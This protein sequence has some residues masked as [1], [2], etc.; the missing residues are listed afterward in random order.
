MASTGW[1]RY[2]E[3]C[4]YALAS[5]WSVLFDFVLRVVFFRASPKSLARCNAKNVLQGS[6]APTPDRRRLGP[7]QTSG[8]SNI[9]KSKEQ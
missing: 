2:Q 1:S 5:E 4:P 7:V 8:R 3:L 6:P 9:K